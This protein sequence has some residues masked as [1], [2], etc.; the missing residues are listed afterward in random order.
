MPAISSTKNS[1]RMKR[2][3]KNVFALL[4]EVTAISML[5]FLR[6]KVVD[7]INHEEIK[8]FFT[9]RIDELE[10]AVK[11][12]TDK[13]PDDKAQL[14][15][16]WDSQIKPSLQENGLDAAKAIIDPRKIPSEDNFADIFTK[17]IAATEY[18]GHVHEMMWRPATM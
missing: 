8:D 11:L 15:E 4:L 18:I 7:K 13:N 14:Q 6:N 17:A 16:L 10:M 2:K 3:R 12:R 1:T 9:Q 5:A